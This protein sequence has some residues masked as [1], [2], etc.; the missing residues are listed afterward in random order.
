MG[1]GYYCDNLDILRRCLT[2]MP[3]RLV[4]L[5]RVL[6]P[7][8]SLYLDYEPTAP[9]YLIIVLDGAFGKEDFAA[10]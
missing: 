7:T 10:K 4:E 5:H 2:S 9:H 8:G 3:S 1:T 6:K